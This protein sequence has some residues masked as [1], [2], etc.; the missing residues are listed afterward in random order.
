[1]WDCN[2]L[3]VRMNTVHDNVDKAMVT[4]RLYYSMEG[5]TIHHGHMY[6]SGGT[7]NTYIDI[8]AS[9]GRTK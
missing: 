3:Y 2:V 8:E 4:D 6:P 7:E 5:D 9:S 1:M